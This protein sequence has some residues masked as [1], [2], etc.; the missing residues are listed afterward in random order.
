VR[1]KLVMLD[2]AYGASGVAI[3]ICRGNGQFSGNVNP[4]TGVR[5][6]MSSGN[7]ASDTFTPYGSPT[8]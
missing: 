4:I 7:I 3:R 6:L 1:N 2:C 5:F 8:P